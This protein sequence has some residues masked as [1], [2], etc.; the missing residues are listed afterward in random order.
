MQLARSRVVKVD[1]GRTA[2]GVGNAPRGIVEL[3]ERRLHGDRVDAEVGETFG[4]AAAPRF[5]FRGLPLVRDVARKNDRADDVIAIVTDRRSFEIDHAVVT[6]A[7]V[8][9]EVIGFD[10]VAA[11]RTDRRQ[12]ARFE[13]TAIDVAVLILPQP[14]LG[15]GREQRDRLALRRGVHPLQLTSR[16][17]DRCRLRN[18]VEDGIDLGHLADGSFVQQRVV[19]RERGVAA[20]LREQRD[21]FITPLARRR[22]LMKAERPRLVVARTKHLNH[23][24]AD[25][26]SGS[27]LGIE[28]GIAFTHRD[29][30]VRCEQPA[31]QISRTGQR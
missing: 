21:F 23:F 4:A 5:A 30:A 9:H 7:R 25:L 31:N 6:G 1:H 28:I 27:V 26:E 18:L 13:R 2:D 14:S 11:Q 24:A 29:R 22:T 17:V 15:I 3:F 8:V 12:I 16:I 10:D 20:D 19:E